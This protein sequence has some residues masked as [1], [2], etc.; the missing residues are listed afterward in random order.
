MTKRQPAA[1]PAIAVSPYLSLRQ[2]VRPLIFAHALLAREQERA[3]QLAGECARLSQLT[4]DLLEA[5]A[6]VH[7]LAPGTDEETSDSAD[8]S[9]RSQLIGAYAKAGLMWAE[10]TGSALALADTL[11]DNDNWNDVYRL[12]DFL[13]ATGEQPAAQDLR[14]RADAT[15]KRAN[16]ILLAK[17]HPAMTETEIAE[18]IEAMRE[19]KGKAAV[20]FYI[21]PLQFA[22]LSAA[23]SS[24]RR[25]S[26]DAAFKGSFGLRWYVKVGDCLTKGAS[27]GELSHYRD[28]RW[29]K[30]QLPLQ[31]S[32]VI[33]GLLV[34]D[35][36]RV[37]TP[38]ALASVIEIPDDIAQL[39]VTQ[40]KREISDRLEVLALIFHQNQAENMRVGRM[41][42]D[43]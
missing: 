28:S 37:D 40:D 35:D 1:Q 29:N 25:R 14:T 3:G 36:S 6:L 39:L 12:A 2:A 43:G 23:P 30:F 34:S 38:T 20:S 41:A 8:D 16:E 13:D 11:L 18:S 26:F 32:A 21:R 9:R 19:S 33:T 7:L 24:W 42:P 17:I 10:V 15:A 5:A 27:I 22:I 4:R 31:F